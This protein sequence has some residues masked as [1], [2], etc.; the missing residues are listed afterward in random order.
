MCSLPRLH[1]L[2]FAVCFICR[3]SKCSAPGEQ[4]SVPDLLTPRGD[5]KLYVDVKRSLEREGEGTLD[6]GGEHG[7]VSCT[8]VSELPDPSHLLL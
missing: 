5:Y 8:Q 7:V 2:L 6:L 3:Q 4:T 1:P